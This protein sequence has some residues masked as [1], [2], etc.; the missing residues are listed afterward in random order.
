GG[1][2]PS[3]AVVKKERLCYILGGYKYR[4]NKYDS[5]RTLQAVEEILAEAEAEAG[6]KIWY[7][8]FLQNCEHF[9]TELRY[10]QSISHELCA[11]PGVS[12]RGAAG[13]AGLQLQEVPLQGPDASLGGSG[14]VGRVLIA[15]SS[16]SQLLPVP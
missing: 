4:V 7:N 2:A 13:G 9:V 15:T 11:S 3:W 14:S 1:L 8:V 10:G 5:K 6:R 16:S 12:V